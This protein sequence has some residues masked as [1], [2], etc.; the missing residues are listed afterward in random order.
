MATK[1]AKTMTPK[2]IT[3]ALKVI[4]EPDRRAM[5]LLSLKGGLRAI[6]IAGL[7]WSQV[8]F[9]DNYL[10]L[11]TTKG[12]E[13]R[14][15]WMHDDVR[16]ALH[17][18]FLH[19]DV[20]RHPHVFPAKASRNGTLGQRVTRNA[21][22]RWFRYLYS[23]TLG[24]EGYSSHSGRRTFCTNLA[25]DAVKHRGSIQDVR[26]LM[27]HESLQT[28]QLYIDEDPGAQQRMVKGL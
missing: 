3:D 14:D 24:W 12:R 27:G 19:C 22:S 15:I 26:K 8:D 25:R 11:K 5:F 1:K 2:R 7:D 13:P 23:N 18:W 20:E 16:A 9:D 4:Y 10:R 28:T 21:V 6:E 17:E